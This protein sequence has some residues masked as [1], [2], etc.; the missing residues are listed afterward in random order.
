MCRIP[1]P[2]DHWPR[3]SGGGGRSTLARSRMPVANFSVLRLPA[4]VT[5]TLFLPLS[6]RGKGRRYAP[7]YEG[8]AYVYSILCIL[9]N[10]LIMDFAFQ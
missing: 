8:M 2:L 3:V 9:R 10:M 6:A 1:R 4:T 7:E 5:Q